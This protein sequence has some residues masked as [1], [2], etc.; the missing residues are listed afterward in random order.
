MKLVSR[1]PGRTVY[2]SAYSHFSQFVVGPFQES[3]VYQL[4]LVFPRNYSLKQGLF[5]SQT[6][7]KSHREWLIDLE[8]VVCV[9]Y[10]QSQRVVLWDRKRLCYPQ[11]NSSWTFDSQSFY[12]F[13]LQKMLDL[14]I[15][16]DLIGFPEDLA[17][18]F[19]FLSKDCRIFKINFR[20]L[21]LEFGLRQQKL[22]Y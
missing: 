18:H 5:W 13:T 10:G 6:V 7:G 19:A 22:I 8:L 21:T 1:I 20:T 3:A 17:K 12:T 16:F 15:V 14:I 2:C 9:G 11:G 4:E